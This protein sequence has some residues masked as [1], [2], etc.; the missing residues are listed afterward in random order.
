LLMLF[1]AMQTQ[2]T[3]WVGSFGCLLSFSH[4]F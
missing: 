3:T 4:F 1:F 2:I